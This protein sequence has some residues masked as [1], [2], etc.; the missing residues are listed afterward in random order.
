MSRLYIMRFLFAILV[1]MWSV[2]SASACAVDRPVVFAGLDW[3]SNAFHTAVAQFILEQ[4]YGC[5]TDVV[6][7]TTIPLLQGVAQ[8]DV[9]IV[10]EVWKDNVTEVWNRGLRRKQVVEIGT[11]FP[12]A[13]QGWYVPRY[14]VEGEGAVAPA[15]ISVT[16]LPAHKALFTD[17]EEPDK[18][19][20]YNCI[21][22]WNCEVI[23]SAK[24]KAY[25]LESDFTNFRPGTGAALA[26][27]IA[28]SYIRKKPIVTYYWGPTWV[29]GKYDMVMLEEPPFDADVFAD[30][31]T[32]PSPTTATAYPVVE[33]AIGAN[34]H[35]ANN[36]PEIVSFLK[37]YET[38][39]A[40]VSAALA[41][42]E[43]TGGQ[44]EGAARHFLRTRADVWSE[45]VEQEPA[46][47]ITA[48]LASME[49]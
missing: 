24:L 45:W 37:R 13:V 41:Y 17:P 46:A 5:E 33:V 47:K 34:R 6:P 31:V 21:A 16:D 30:L 2:S 32:N 11:N 12:D 18:G 38:N 36:A 14:M 20:F 26:A 43:E 8:G 44:A 23:N 25:G 10:M 3:Q 19:R 9:D 1:L 48:T 28:S 35:F 15:L 7:G 49:N 27:A 29:L 40:L 39:A 42:M 22:G 4:G